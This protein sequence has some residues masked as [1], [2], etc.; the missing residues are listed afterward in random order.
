MI[1]NLIFTIWVGGLAAGWATFGFAGSPVPEA[2]QGKIRTQL[3]QQGYDVHKIKR[4]DGLY[5]AYV[6]KEGHRLEVYLDRDMNV[7]RTKNQD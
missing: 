4:E 1:R 7:I 2:I 6:V 5:E 3:I